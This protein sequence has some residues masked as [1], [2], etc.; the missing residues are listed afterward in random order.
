MTN[1]RAIFRFV[2]LLFAT[3]GIYGFWFLLRFFIPNK[4]YWRQ[5]T[6][7]MWAKAWV[8]ISGIEIEVI[9]TPP[10]PP[11]F[12]VG[13]HLGYIDIPVVRSVAKGVFVAKHDIGDWFMFGNMI[14]NMGTIYVNRAVKRDIPR[15][16]EEVIEMLNGGEGVIVFPEGTSSKGEE[17]LP[18]NSS[19]LAFAAKTDVPVS[20]L[21]ISYRTPEGCPPPSEAICWWDDTP[22]LNHV[23]RLLSVKKFTA[24][25]NFGD[26]PIVN[27]DR[28]QL[29]AELRSHVAERFVPML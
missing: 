23:L 7:E 24:I 27:P 25:L 20:Y 17:V 22:F 16:G 28:K 10:Q 26:E 29:A 18:F 5:M 14:R 21:S 12:L 6:L 11:F 4:Q 2:L 9:G 1:L 8:R 15:A 3:F 13:N 19:F